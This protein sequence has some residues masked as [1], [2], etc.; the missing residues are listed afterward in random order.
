[1]QMKVFSL[2][3][4]DIMEP[5]MQSIT[6]KIEVVTIRTKTEKS[7]PLFIFFFLFHY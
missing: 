7:H 1:M 4:L 6:F 3:V 5:I 2:S